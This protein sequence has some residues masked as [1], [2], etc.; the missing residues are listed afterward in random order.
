VTARRAAVLIALLLAFTVLLIAVQLRWGPLHRLD[1]D[2]ADDLNARLRRSAGTV[3]FWQDISDVLHPYVLRGVA[4]VAALVLW[5]RGGRREAVFVVLS[6]ALT[7]AVESIVKV[8]VDRARPAFAHPLS[9]AAGASFPSGH[10]ITSFVAFGLLALLAPR[11]ARLPAAVVAVALAALV[12]FSR[13]A[14]GVHYVSDVL[15]AWLL[16]AA[17]LVGTEAW[18]SR[19]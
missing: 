17:V 14:L 16:G 13:I 3:R 9:H 1:A 15:G 8:L 19:R 4:A 10:A 5:L 18:F 7:A 11:R 12:G 6:M 2:T